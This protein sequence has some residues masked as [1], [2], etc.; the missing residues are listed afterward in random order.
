[1]KEGDGVIPSRPY[2]VGFS[3]QMEHRSP[4]SCVSGAWMNQQVSPLL[5]KPGEDED[6]GLAGGRD[7]P[8]A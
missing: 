7:A 4:S 6:G 3:R 8:W 2:V 5:Q 1:M